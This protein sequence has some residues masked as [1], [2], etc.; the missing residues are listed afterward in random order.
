MEMNYA[1]KGVANAG[2]ATGIVG[3]ALGALNS[4]MFNGVLG[5]F[6]GFGG[7]YGFGNRGYGYGGYGCGGYGNYSGECDGS[8]PINRFEAV[9]MNEISS[10]DQRISL[11]ES[12]IYTD[13]KLADVY[14]RLDRKIDGVNAQLGQQAAFNA[15]TISNLNCIQGQVAQLYGLT[16]LVVPN[17]SVCPGWGEVTI[18]PTPAATT[19]A[20]GA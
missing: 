14:E 7:G 18:T 10:K 3:T 5:G 12:N 2:L 13:Q 8:H 16:R 15:A 9:M 20:A 17:T 1:S 19:A 6:G 11:L 4:G